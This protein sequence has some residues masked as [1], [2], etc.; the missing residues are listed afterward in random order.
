MEAARHLHPV[1]DG[2]NYREVA[3]QIT[4]GEAKV[5]DLSTGEATVE[6]QD[7]IVGL[8]R[9]IE[10]QGRKIG[11]LERT[12]NDFGEVDPG[13][14]GREITDLIDR[15]RRGTG[16]SKAKIGKPRI[17]LVKARLADGFPITCPDWL[18]DHVTLELAIDGIAAYP[19]R[20]FK[21][22][23]REGS[24]SELENDLSHALKDE[25]HVEEC[26]RYGY[27]A[28]KAGWTLEGWPNG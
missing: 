16:K 3:R 13:P 2:T 5:I 25:K 26:A 24:E 14:A 18:P 1:P 22:R 8:F 10:S 11:S 23:R 20:R 6:A 15:W 28:R 17:K 19:Y 21:E 27:K 4:K 12:I 7:L 9:T